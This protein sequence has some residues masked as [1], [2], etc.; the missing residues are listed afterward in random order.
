M[1]PNDRERGNIEPIVWLPETI[2][3]AGEGRPP[4]APSKGQADHFMVMLPPV[5]F[6]ASDAPP[7][8]RLTPEEPV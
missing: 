2:F 5:V 4:E 1:T 7:E 6:D 8:S 3:D